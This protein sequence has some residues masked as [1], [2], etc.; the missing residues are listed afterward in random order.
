MTGM[1]THIQSDQPYSSSS[2]SSATSAAAPARPARVWPAVVL[3]ALYWAVRVV[4]NAMD[5]TISAH[6]ITSVLVPG[7][8]VLLFL[9][10]WL[11]CLRIPFVERFGGL[12]ALAA[13]TYLAAKASHPSIGG[14]ALLFYALPLGLTLWTVWL[15]LGGRRSAF[16]QRWGA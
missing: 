2:P 6:F 14:F 12:V 15:A 4:T 8:I 7:V 13:G 1:S 9:V 5:M 16:A 11:T 10:W 3:I